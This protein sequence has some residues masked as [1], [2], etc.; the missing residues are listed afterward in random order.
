MILTLPFQM[1]YVGE[2]PEIKNLQTREKKNLK[3]KKK[4]G[5]E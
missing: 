2:K 5:L 1:L 4:S 3:K